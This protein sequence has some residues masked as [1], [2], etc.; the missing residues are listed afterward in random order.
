M[1]SDLEEDP[2]VKGIVDHYLKKMGA[3]MGKQIG[4]TSVDLDGRFTKVRTQETNLG[5]LVTDIMRAWCDSAGGAD[6]VLLNS[7]KW[8]HALAVPEEASS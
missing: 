3:S 7:G 5:N 8:C 2:E 6:V 4:F 1:T